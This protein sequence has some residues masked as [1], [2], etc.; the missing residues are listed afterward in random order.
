LADGIAYFIDN[1]DQ[2][3][4]MGRLAKEKFFQ[5]FTLEVFEDNMCR[6]FDTVINSSD[7]NGA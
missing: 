4:L 2:R 3:I 7:N 5:K 6:V 1:P